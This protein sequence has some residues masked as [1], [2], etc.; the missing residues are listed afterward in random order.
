MFCSGNMILVNRRPFVLG[1]HGALYLRLYSA[2]W[3]LLLWCYP[4]CFLDLTLQILSRVTLWK[5]LIRYKSVRSPSSL[6]N[7]MLI[8]SN[9]KLHNDSSVLHNAFP[10]IAWISGQRALLEKGVVHI[11]NNSTC[12]VIRGAWGITSVL[13][14]STPILSQNEA[15]IILDK[16][17]GSHMYFSC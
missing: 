14:G 17:Y 9:C 4:R 8:L 16:F 13:C 11:M 1:S 6:C 5:K 10:F 12:F 2:D 15:T 7:T 3:T